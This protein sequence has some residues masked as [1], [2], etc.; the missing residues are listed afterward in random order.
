MSCF[1][2][3]FTVKIPN[4]HTDPSHTQSD[5]ACFD[6]TEQEGFLVG[7]LGNET[8][9]AIS[10]DKYGTSSVVSNLVPDIIAQ[11]HGTPGINQAGI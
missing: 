8:V 3:F 11:T 7:L 1:S 10:V 9:A 4:S 5:A 6:A 2:W